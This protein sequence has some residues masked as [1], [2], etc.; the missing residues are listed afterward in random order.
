MLSLNQLRLIIGALREICKSY[1]D[2]ILKLEDQK[3]DVEYQVARKD[4][5]ARIP[6]IFFF[7]EKSY[8][9]KVAFYLVNPGTVSLCFLYL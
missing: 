3:Y 2:K 1:Y 4:M 7:F 6:Y 5:E 8:F 9:F